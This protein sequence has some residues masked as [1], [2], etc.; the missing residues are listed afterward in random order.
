[1]SAGPDFVN[2]D[3]MICSDLGVI[4]T[5]HVLQKKYASY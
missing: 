3:V 1:M 5:G 4:K 2:D